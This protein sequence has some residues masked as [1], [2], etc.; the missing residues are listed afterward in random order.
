MRNNGNTP[1]IAG[2]GD[3]EAR[4][5]GTLHLAWSDSGLVSLTFAE[6][7]PAPLTSVELT[8]IPRDW[9]EVLTGYFAGEEVDPVRIPVDLRGAGTAF[10]TEVWEAL[11]RIPR[12]QVRTYVGIA[13]D[14]GR[15][16][17]M[18]AVGMANAKNPIAIV[19]PCHRVVEVGLRLGGYSAGI[20]R[21]VQLLELEGVKVVG[22]AVRPG[23][24][25]LL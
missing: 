22:D 16:R 5:V 20:P 21:K 19:V 25:G 4:G 14:V 6:E 24:L 2:R 9:V 3:F 13:A 15:P 12:G 11:R 10:Q 7:V 8:A 1:A 18:R 17:G 23:Q